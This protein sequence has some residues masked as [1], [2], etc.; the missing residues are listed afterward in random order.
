MHLIKT[1]TYIVFIVTLFTA[2]NLGKNELNTATIG[3]DVLQSH[4]DSS[5]N[6]ADDF[7]DYAN[8]GWIKSHAIPADQSSW[9]IGD[10]VIEENLNR[11][12]KINEDAAKANASQGSTEQK[13]GDFWKTAM[14]SSAIEQQGLKPLQP[15]LSKIDSITD[16]NSFAAVDAEL[17]KIGVNTLVGFYVTQDDKNSD[18]M[19]VK[20]R[21]SGLFLPDRE[22]YFKK[23]STSLAIDKAYKK[24][25]KN[26]LVMSGATD[27]ATATGEAEKIF[28]METGLAKSHR[29]IEDLRDPN[30]NYNKLKAEAFYKLT[31]S[32]HLNA[33]MQAQGTPYLDSIIVGQPDYYK[34]LEET[35]KTF[36]VDDWKLFL[37]FRLIN[38][39][40][41][42]LP[43]AYGAERFNF[44]KL[45]TGTQ[46]QQPRWKRTLRDEQNVMGELL[47]QQFVKKY[48]DSTAKKRYEDLVE[49][50]RTSLKNHIENLSWMSDTTKQKALV[51]L[52]TIKKKVGY[53]DKWKDYSN[54]HVGTD[55]YV[56]NMINGNLWR[57]QYQL[58]KLGKP[59]D[60]TEWGMTPQTYNAQYE[61][62]NN[63]ITLPAAIFTVPGY[64]DDQLDDAVVYGYAG[65]STI[66]HEITHGFDDEGRQY[67]EQGNL[68]NW[69]TKDDE[70]K[71][72]KR[73]QVM[74]N[75][76]GNYVVVD[77]FKI[78]GKASLGENIADLGGIVLAWDAFKQTD[79]YKD[80]QKIAGLTPAQRFFL[81]YALG[82]ME[83]DRPQSLRSQVL[84]DVHSPAKFRVNGPFS[85]VD[86]FYETFNVKPGNKMYLPDSARVR[87]W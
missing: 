4:I 74:I 71:F 69:W 14:D 67:D 38:A 17:N 39:F 46:E 86:A 31:P 3:K 64:T 42:Q 70:M 55:S 72:N 79:Q 85:D 26:V 47:G 43:N 5:I 61:P 49:A 9:G 45:L 76:F 19:I 68:K 10:L 11:L 24:Y 27:S 8:G 30:L 56:Q 33:F 58:N 81:G 87:I 75:Q 34:Q 73:A 48:F 44:L 60:R 78:N 40:A 65:A 35:V 57:M 16:L 7:F 22:F 54:L 50:I 83:S 32:L 18:S 15:Y 13:I 37:K 6:P 36:K 23:D 77:T 29:K 59:V 21:Q 63:E 53:P 82:W 25:I 66:G 41:N 1:T 52:A 12:R 80:Q 28:A 62:S 2:C 51:K 20:F 84:S